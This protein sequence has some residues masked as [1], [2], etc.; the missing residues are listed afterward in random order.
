MPLENLHVDPN[1]GLGFWKITESEEDLT[2]QFPF[3]RAVPANLNNPQKRLEWMA[4]R[5]LTH[6]LLAEWNLPFTGIVKDTFGKPFLE[7]LN[8]HLSMTHSFP[9]V[10]V[11]V[12]REKNVGIDLEQPKEKLLRIGPRVLNPSELSDAGTDMIKHCIYWCSKETLIKI[13]GRKDLTLAK[14]LQV[15]AFIVGLQGAIIGRI[16]VNDSERVVPLYYQ[17]TPEFIVVYNQ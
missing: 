16:I 1:R 11:I 6:C 15:D 7:G 4:G 17:V 9:Y 3:T 5:V 8:V 13:Y 10:S 2:R 14:N 12:D